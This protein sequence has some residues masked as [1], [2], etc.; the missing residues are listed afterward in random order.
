VDASCLVMSN[1]PPGRVVL[2]R[3]VPGL[4]GRRKTKTRQHLRTTRTDRQRPIVVAI[5]TVSAA[6]AG[7]STPS[8]VHSR[9]KPLVSR[10]EVCTERLRARVCLRLSLAAG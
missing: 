1:G 8:T 5:R 10:A 6:P 7:R 2:G 9:L 3:K 4:N